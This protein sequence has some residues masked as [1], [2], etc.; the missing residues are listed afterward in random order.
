MPDAEYYRPHGRGSDHSD[1][2]HE[3]LRSLHDLR[4]ELRESRTELSRLRKTLEEHQ[5][6]LDENS[7]LVEALGKALTAVLDR[8]NIVR[9]IGGVFGALLSRRRGGG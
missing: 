2:Q 6:S 7:D 3:F 5:Q 4:V 9:G 8:L 1:M